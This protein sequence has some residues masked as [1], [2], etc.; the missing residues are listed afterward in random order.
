MMLPLAG[1]S[2]TGDLVGRLEHLQAG[3][4]GLRMGSDADITQV[5]QNQVGLYRPVSS[6]GAQPATSTSDGTAMT[7]GTSLLSKEAS[8]DQ[9]KRR[10]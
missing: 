6:T 5:L 8:S 10:K 3:S 1:S 2:S 9:A 7:L 4:T